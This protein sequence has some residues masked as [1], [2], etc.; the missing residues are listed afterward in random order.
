MKPGQKNH[1][2]LDFMRFNHPEMGVCIYIYLYIKYYINSLYGPHNEQ[3]Q[4]NY[5][6]RMGLHV[7]NLYKTWNLCWNMDGQM[8]EVLVSQPFRIWSQ[9]V[10][11]NSPGLQ[12]HHR[13][14]S[15]DT[16]KGTAGEKN[17]STS[18][19]RSILSTYLGRYDNLT[20]ETSW[21]SANWCN[22]GFQM[23]QHKPTQR[24]MRSKKMGNSDHILI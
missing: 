9:P 20:P 7:W 10:F 3:I 16:K 14:T 8:A 22:I 13:S 12:L 6:I 19:K 4:D 2:R 18:H 15:P 17:V 1:W 5:S 23:M 11:S 21:N 24:N